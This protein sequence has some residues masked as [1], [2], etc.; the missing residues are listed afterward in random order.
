MERYRVSKRN[1]VASLA[2]AIDHRLQLDGEMELSAIGV[3]ANHIALKAV[4]SLHGFVLVPAVHIRFENIDEGE[5]QYK[6]II[7]HLQR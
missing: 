6:A 2:Q 7:Y 1:Q 3:E 4:A 5:R